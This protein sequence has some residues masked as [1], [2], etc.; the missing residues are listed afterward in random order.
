MRNEL[1]LSAHA[2]LATLTG[3]LSPASVAMA[4]LDWS[5]HMA[6]APGKALDLERL[7]RHNDSL[8]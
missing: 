2:A 6:L 4:A 8:R 1:D 3:G 5:F 7:A